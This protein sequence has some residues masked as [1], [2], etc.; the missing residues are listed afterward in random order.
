MLSLLNK[1]NKNEFP[2][3]PKHK[4][5][6]G[7]FRPKL[8]IG[9]LYTLLG[10]DYK[11]F[12]YS[13]TEYILRYSYLNKDYDYFRTYK[14]EDNNIIDSIEDKEDRLKGYRYIDEVKDIKYGGFIKWIPL[15]DPSYLPLNAG[16]IISDIKVTDNGLIL[17][18]KN[19]MHKYYQ[20]KMDEC[21]IFQ[22][23]SNQEQVLLSA[24][25]HLAK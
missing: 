21:L 24:L 8:Y 22:K 10:V 3:N 15:Q 19:F 13:T 11:M 23:L 25:D 18:Y 1:E 4:N 9:K 7:S 14:I 6:L 17:V 16:G 12:D 20:I 5:I 2:F